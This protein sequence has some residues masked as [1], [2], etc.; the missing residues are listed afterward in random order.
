VGA[1]DSFYVPST[2]TVGGPNYYYATLS[3]GS[4]I[5]KSNISTV[6]NILAL[7]NISS[8]SSGNQAY[9]SG[10]IPS[11]LVVSATSGINNNNI[12][13]Q[14]YVN[15]ANSFA[16]ATLIP[17][18]TNA[19]LTFDTNAI[20][21]I[22]RRFYFVNI[23]NGYNTCQTSSTAGSIDILA[24]PSINSYQ[25]QDTT[26]CL[27][28]VSRFL[29]VSANSNNG[30]VLTYQ[31]YSNF[32]NDTGATK[33]IVA[34]AAG[35]LVS[36]RPPT[37]VAGSTTYYFVNISNGNC[38]INSPVSG[39]I[40][41][42]AL[43]TISNEQLIR[44]NG[45]FFCQN[46]TTSN[47]SISNNINYNFQWY[48]SIADDNW[49]L[50]N[51][52][53][54]NSYS[55]P[56]TVAG[57]RYYRVIVT[58]NLS[59]CASTSNVSGKITILPAPSFN[60]I[61]R[62]NNI[63]CL[64]NIAQLLSITATNGSL[65]NIRY[66]W[67]R[68][69]VEGTTLGD[70]VGETN[71]Y[72]PTTLAN[73][74]GNNYY[75]VVALNTDAPQ[76]SSCSTSTSTIVGQ[77]QIYNRPTISN[78]FT[79]N[80][81]YCQNQKIGIQAINSNGN[82]GG[83]GTLTYQWYYN[84]S[85]DTFN[86]NPI[87]GATSQSFNGISTSQFGS[88]YYYVVYH[89]GSGLAC[90]SV[91]SRV[92]V[93][94]TINPV[95][96]IN[97][98]PA[99]LS[100]NV[101]V[102]T[103]LN[104][105]FVV[106]TN[107]SGGGLTY[108]WYR[109]NSLNSIGNLINV[110]GTNSIFR[111]DSSQV[112][113]SSYYSVVVGNLGCNT[114]SNPSGK[115]I[116]N[117]YPIIIGVVA[118]S[119]NYCQNQTENINQI[120]V[121]ATDAKGGTNLNYRWF[122]N[123]IP[124]TVGY[125]VTNNLTNTIIPA[126]VNPGVFYY[127]L[128][129]TNALPTNTCRTSII[130]Q[131]I[132]VYSKPNIT[133]I[134]LLANKYCINQTSGVDTLRISVSNLNNETFTYRWYS[135]TVNN[136]SVAPISLT[137]PGYNTNAYRPD[138]SSVG[139]N[140]YIAIVSNDNIPNGFSCKTDTSNFSGALE[141]YASP[142]FNGIS[143]I[144]NVYCQGITPDTL[145]V[146]NASS[147]GYGTLS[148]SW[149]YNFNNNS[150]NSGTLVGSNL[151]FY[152]PSNNAI[153]GN[154]FYYL[155]IR[156]GGP[157]ACD[158]AKSNV[159]TQIIVSV[160]PAITLQP[161]REQTNVCLGS[162][163]DTLFVQA[164]T[165]GVSGT[166]TYQWYR[167]KNLDKSN[168]ILVGGATN[169]NYL[170]IPAT[171]FDTNYY[172]VRVTNNAISNVNCRTTESD[173]S[174]AVYVLSVPSI[175]N[176]FINNTYCR[177]DASF[178]LVANYNPG[179]DASITSF[180]WF[181]N[182]LNNNQNGIPLN[183][184]T[185]AT[186]IVPNSD[187]VGTKYYY[188]R[189]TNTNNCFV[190]SPILLQVN[191]LSKPQIITQPF[192]NSVNTYYCKTLGGVGGNINVAATPVYVG[193]PNLQDNQMRIV[194]Y[195]KP[196]NNN[197]NF[198]D[199][200]TQNIITGTNTSYAIPL[201]NA[202]SAYYFVVAVNS[203]G[204]QVRSNFA[205]NSRGD[206]T[207]IEIAQSPAI[208]NTTM[209]TSRRY[210]VSPSANTN[211][212]S[213]NPVLAIDNIQWYVSSNI[214]LSNRSLISGPTATSYN[215]SLTNSG[216]YYYYARYNFSPAACV[217]STILLA[218]D[219][220]FNV[221]TATVN[222][223]DTANYCTSSINIKNLQIN[224]SNGA[225][226]ALTYQWYVNSLP[227]ATIDPAAQIGA[228]SPSLAPDL[229]L[230]GRNY[231]YVQVINN[232]APMGSNC[233]TYLSTISGPISVYGTPTVS[234]DGNSLTNREY[235]QNAVSSYLN[236]KVNA[237]TGGFGVLGIRWFRDSVNNINNGVLIPG[238][239]GT[240]L[241]PLNTPIDTSY[242]HVIV[243][244]GSKLPGCDSVYSTL[245]G[246]IIILP[247]PTI[248]MLRLDS[249]TYCNNVFSPNQGVSPLS[250]T[251]LNANNGFQWY[252][253]SVVSEIGTPIIN[254]VFE[255]YIPPIDVVEISY[256]RVVALNSFCATTS[257]IAAKIT[258]NALPTINGD[259][260]LANL[261]DQ[262]ICQFDTANAPILS[263][264]GTDY[265]GQNRLTYRWFR[266]TTSADLNSL[267]TVGRDSS[268]ITANVTVPGIYFYIVGVFNNYPNNTCGTTSNF[269][270]ATVKINQLPIITQQP[271]TNNIQLCQYSV[272][273][274][275]LV[276]NAT[277]PTSTI[278]G[279]QWFSNTTNATRAGALL[280]NLDNPTN[281]LQPPTNLPGNS[282]TY[283]FSVV[284]DAIGCTS[285][286]NYSGSVTINFSPIITQN[287]T[288]T[289][290]TNGVLCLNNLSD[291]LKV[292]ARLNSGLLPTY[293]WYRTASNISSGTAIGLNSRANNY[294]IPTNTLG[295]NYYYLIITDQAN[296]CTSTSN[297]SEQYTVNP[298]PQITVQPDSINYSFCLRE[299]A[300]QT[301]FIGTQNP[302]F[303]ITWY[304]SLSRGSYNGTP[305][306]NSNS[307]SIVILTDALSSTYYYAIVTDLIGCNATSRQ[308]GNIVI[309]N[310]PVFSNTPATDITQICYGI[311]SPQM[312]VLVSPPAG[313]FIN[314]IIWISSSNST[315]SLVVDTILRGL[316]S[317]YI[318]KDSTL[319]LF[320]YQ[321]IV[322]A[323]NG[324]TAISPILRNIQVNPI[325]ILPALSSDAS[326]IELCRNSNN[327]KTVNIDPGVAIYSL[328]WF[329]S[330]T[331]FYPNVSANVFFNIP[332][333]NFPDYLPN[334]SDTGNN[335]YYMIARNEFNCATTS[336]PSGNFRIIP[337]PSI[338]AINIPNNAYCINS[339]P[340]PIVVVANSGI[341][342]NNLTYQWYV[343]TQ[344]TNNIDAGAVPVTTPSGQTRNLL[345]NTNEVSSN[346]YFVQI[347]NAFNCIVLSNITPLIEVV[348]TPFFSDNSYQIDGINYSI[349][350]FTLNP[351]VISINASAGLNGGLLNSTWY[352]SSSRF[353]NG[354]SFGYIP[355]NLTV[356]TDTASAYYYYQV[357]TQTK[358][359]CRIT[360]DISGLIQINPVPRI[361]VGLNPSGIQ[362]LTYCQG[363]ALNTL[364][365]TV[366]GGAAVNYSWYYATTKNYR[367][368]MLIPGNF[369]NS[370]NPPNDFVNSRYY[371]AKVTNQV[372]GCAAISDFSTEYIVYSRPSI[373]YSSGYFTPSFFCT[374]GASSNN[375][376]VFGSDLSGSTIRYRWYIVSQ[377]DTNN[378]MNL[379]ARDTLNNYLP[380][381]SIPGN[382]YFK[383]VL[384]NNSPLANCQTTTSSISGLASVYDTPQIISLS[385]PAGSIDANYCLNQGAPVNP[386]TVNAIQGSGNNNIN[387]E[388]FIFP[389]N[390]PRTSGSLF[391]S[392]LNLSSINVP[393]ST[394]GSFKFYAII[395]NSNNCY[396]T[397][398]NTGTVNIN[399]SPNLISNISPTSYDYCLSSPN[400]NTVS[401][402]TN[403]TAITYQWYQVNL[404]TN[405]VNPVGASTKIYQPNNSVLNARYFVTLANSFNCVLTSDTSGTYR[406][407]PDPAIPT[408][409]PQYQSYCLNRIDTTPLVISNVS[410]GIGAPIYR[411]FKSRNSDGSLGYSI[412]QNSTYTPLLDTVGTF[413]YYATISFGAVYGCP[414]LRTQIT[415]LTINS[416]PIISNLT[417]LQTNVNY[418]LRDT[419]KP[420][421]ITLNNNDNL[422]YTY[423][424]YRT[425]NNNNQSGQIINGATDSSY[426][427]PNNVVSS[428][429]YFSIVD[430]G[431]CQSTSR[432]SGNINIRATPILSVQP[433]SRDTTYTQGFLN[434]RPLT[435]AVSGAS[436]VPATLAI[437]YSTAD[438]TIRGDS[439]RTGFS[440]PPITTNISSNYYYAVIVG[441]NS[442]R[443][444]SNFSGKINVIP[445]TTITMQPST[446]AATYCQNTI[447]T[448]N[449]SVTVNPGATII[450]HYR[451]FS[452][453][454]APNGTTRT[455]SVP[456]IR[457]NTIVP[458]TANA[459][460]Y[461]YFVVVYNNFNQTITSNN[462]G[463]ITVTSRAVVNNTNMRDT[464]YCNSGNSSIGF[465]LTG[466]TGETP[467][468]T[469]FR[470]TINS[471]DGAQQLNQT[472]SAQTWQLDKTQAGSFFYFARI[473]YPLQQNVECQTLFTRISNIKIFEPISLTG[474][475]LIPAATYCQGQTADV[476][477]LTPTTAYTTYPL[478]RVRI[479]W[480]SQT[481]INNVTSGAVLLPD[482]TNTLNVITNT[483]GTNRYFAR[484]YNGAPL[485]QSCAVT[486]STVETITI[487]TAPFI[488][489]QPL[490]VNLVGLDQTLI[491][492]LTVLT[493]TPQNLINYTW[494]S[495]TQNRNSNGLVIPGAIFNTYSPPTNDTNTLYYYVQISYINPTSQE[496]NTTVSNVASV[497]VTIKP[498]ITGVN[499]LDTS[500]CLGATA[501][502]IEVSSTK[503]GAPIRYNWYVSPQPLISLATLIVS[504]TLG[505]YRPQT[506]TPGSYYYFCVVDNGG[507]LGYGRDT[508][509]PIRVFIDDNS[510]FLINLSRNKVQYCKDD[511][512][513]HGS[514]RVI[515]FNPFYTYTY[516]WYSYNRQTSQLNI[517]ED[518]IDTV[519][520]PLDTA[521]GK[522]EYFV[523]VDNHTFG[524]TVGCNTVTS[525]IATNTVWDYPK[526][527]TQPKDS[528]YC[529]G[530][531]L[532]P[533]S[534]EADGNGSPLIYQWY[535]TNSTLKTDSTE[536][537]GV[538]GNSFT[539]T[540]PFDSFITFVRVSTSGNNL[541]CSSRSTR[542]AK[543]TIIPTPLL[544]ASDTFTTCS[545]ITFN[546]TLSANTS[547]TTINW[548]RQAVTGISNRT[549]SGQ[550]NINEVL[551]NSNPTPEPA[552]PKY[553]VNLRTRDGCTNM[554]SFIVRVNPTPTIT[555]VTGGGNPLN[556]RSVNY[557]SDPNSAFN[558]R[559]AS[560]INSSYPNS[561]FYWYIRDPS[562]TNPITTFGTTET[563]PSFAL[564]NSSNQ[565]ET[566]AIILEVNFNGCVSPIDSIVMTV[567]PPIPHQRIQGTAEVC[568]GVAPTP[569]YI[570]N[571]N[572]LENNPPN[573][574]TYQWQY[575]DTT[576]SASFQDLV[577]GSAR[578]RVLQAPIQ[579]RPKY[580]RVITT[581][582]CQDISETFK[583]DTLSVPT[584]QI[585]YKQQ[586]IIGYGG[587]IDIALS[588]AV[589]YDWSP[590]YAAE[591]LNLNTFVLTLSPTP[592]V[593]A[594]STFTKYLITGTGLNQ[595]KSVDSF[596]IL[597]VLNYN[598]NIPNVGSSS[599]VVSPNGDNI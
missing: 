564:V 263:I 161:K 238:Q 452:V 218:G 117:S 546:L 29:S 474:G 111:I 508:T 435:V 461:R 205:L 516:Q 291:T 39:A 519:Y 552:Y 232:L 64:N 323:S 302:N 317:S 149:Y 415:Q 258:V 242:Y 270:D 252:K 31:W 266:S 217:D 155:I 214:N 173:A 76:N 369:G 306:A 147:G 329:R 41:V 151:P 268:V 487:L 580:Y 172:F 530:N 585:S 356:S 531:K 57:A 542:V 225:A 82:A 340:Q 197:F 562:K 75:Y 498:D 412:S 410:G 503:G 523:L 413:Y 222:N 93:E 351:N 484:L 241:R 574:S 81:S 178:P 105:L 383:D 15:T 384:T 16:G 206:I 361:T 437:W 565:I 409:E 355:N 476:L 277:S 396:T 352:R 438:T 1:T 233:S 248:T 79:S 567:A 558:V 588:G 298:L 504:D 220:I 249:A 393:V 459:G 417:P 280:L 500:Y 208:T 152:I 579:N 595:C 66:V 348:D 506:Q 202:D 449:I 468:V 121:T 33:E 163:R 262:F 48:D 308:S 17:L 3:N 177:T 353:Y 305:I 491:P 94:I 71:T 571:A 88:Q 486:T 223:F 158:S 501:R 256:Y 46:S 362:S 207:R 265:L 259:I 200:V 231:Y 115:I 359:G 592:N 342:D 203:N 170:V 344:P 61:T 496:C 237:S 297:I 557:C 377:S 250:V 555:N 247:V 160:S 451:W 34:T 419:I 112:T 427:I 123:S 104:S 166:L 462:S 65:G 9:C 481:V 548:T 466:G 405:V 380:L 135:S 358:G 527:T 271:S 400:V 51:G 89:N 229:N 330:K 44:P 349:C 27:N 582:G 470:N 5:I 153:G 230:I 210:C 156:N 485:T 318:A 56:N 392:G 77:N 467:T 360:S 404:T 584:I 255:Q 26:Y 224:A 148:Y 310:I 304:R 284:R 324:C 364:N 572:L 187:T 195:K 125:S 549:A 60:T 532:A 379:T 98:Q 373:S 525:N 332:G 357:F 254:E 269:T 521:I 132:T 327:T 179:A 192:I 274:S 370:F 439:V 453:Y 335:Y 472:G 40:N 186:S 371:F 398:S 458:L 512:S 420:L 22:G 83:Y 212:I 129:V 14:W 499:Y 408:A 347:N 378:L 411:W 199:S 175:S 441:N 372:S 426:T 450:T 482:T 99:T 513:E 188:L 421:I 35:R 381:Y 475:D 23:T 113:D 114:T 227:V 568:K 533:L 295:S 67:K 131:A 209:R 276:V 594:D 106:A 7:P 97:T 350:Q 590:K 180:N 535:R 374:N 37:T 479:E 283:Y 447:P 216:Y 13:F 8:V 463:V 536:I 108:Q 538:Y 399:R 38:N 401:I 103:G 176:T 24:R 346:Y 524:G 576:L 473:F 47:L 382:Y 514:F 390:Q 25:L 109:S 87:P 341:S 376:G 52:A 134:N 502:R 556:W 477:Q 583:V 386:I 36:Y 543:I 319:G 321:A 215:S 444:T 154:Y 174:G 74:I 368:S 73:N 520:T 326:S 196:N 54:T 296:S 84:L 211:T 272:P 80:N 366:A 440:F 457:I 367:D 261:T 110:N 544:N 157:A 90:D 518:A 338:T 488:T 455:D 389:A 257:S 162:I 294:A 183:V 528:T 127:I 146:N 144:N 586:P 387:Y 181:Y 507:A 92:P 50:I 325:P 239:T 489:I 62:L 107:V 191:V 101:C 201:T 505:Y 264:S 522:Y 428:F 126:V 345:I 436:P 138:I 234:F 418:C 293:Q 281:I 49:I 596:I 573:N 363:D 464:S 279:Y 336:N 375:L 511:K 429:Y 59:S 509:D 21:F 510:T 407:F 139:R 100:Q 495:N 289:N 534:F 478:G 431:N 577:D 124:S 85:N 95:P 19:N 164:N 314:S 260:Q 165:N 545:N 494:F 432:V 246:Q 414:V 96:V 228:N 10:I 539:P 395:N 471:M 385:F 185:S 454:T 365:I 142:S 537:F 303:P 292:E 561:N 253:S 18:Q 566:N 28:Y 391:S 430:N 448:N 406:F 515:T 312:T 58:A 337:T 460:T 251:A 354:N 145:K 334:T 86:G 243:T 167:S 587:N 287:L 578:T 547:N 45:A 244:N 171:V 235:C 30:Q 286:T 245:S 445:S 554:Q 221:I 136:F 599:I 517:I 589:S 563:I 497:K 169:N 550:G 150:L 529:T 581:F 339:I 597:S 32:I 140:F 133:P 322:S 273:T 267:I 6:T 182:T 275:N 290:T 159:T 551:I 122:T 119:A 198:A 307:E 490:A 20:K 2:T 483:P 42:V 591:N 480:Y 560:V 240:T 69:T 446:A 168:P 328:Q 116:I 309:R 63:Y 313:S 141:V 316:T 43:P 540:L 130:S 526:I 469:W 553:Q 68:T 193:E 189:L 493:S 541:Y 236:L 333:A 343:N 575:S 213:F 394:L 288:T 425:Q 402:S 403:D 315:G 137:N 598:L 91:V 278:N 70:S 204:C 311:P 128:D 120:S 11:D 465:S 593:I 570:I 416:L 190:V 12:T 559:P 388:W 300:T 492:P 226:Q 569:L 456:N 102:G 53:T 4:C 320:R 424:W 422:N 55:I 194:W 433:N 331:N 282:V 118:N 301:L 78:T 443:T 285:T 423:K 219:T 434:P 184:P 299:P 442:C 143:T 72:R 397:S